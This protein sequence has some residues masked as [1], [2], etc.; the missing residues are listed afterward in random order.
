MFLLVSKR[1]VFDASFVKFRTLQCHA[2][3]IYW[4]EIPHYLNMFV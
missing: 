3:N 1:L 2:Q 4:V